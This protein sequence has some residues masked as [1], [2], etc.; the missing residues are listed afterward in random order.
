[1][2]VEPKSTPFDQILFLIFIATFATMTVFELA[3][4]AFYPYPPD[5]RSNLITSLF[6][7]GLAVIIAY[8]PLNAYYAKSVEV[9]SEIERRRLVE[10][11][12][13]ES[14]EKFRGIFDTINDGIH[15]HEIE[16][17]GKPGNS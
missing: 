1:M 17:D 7:S 12:L 16:P 13:R 10:I 14:E 3:G 6:T 4:Q 8:F 9:L 11:E 15:I 2:N 5:W